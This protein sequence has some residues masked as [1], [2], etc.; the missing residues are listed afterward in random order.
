MMYIDTKLKQAGQIVVLVIQ[1]HEV[2]WCRVNCQIIGRQNL[3]SFVLF[4][5][6]L[7][8]EDKDLIKVSDKAELASMYLRFQS[9]EPFWLDE[10]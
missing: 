8:F 2:Y 10:G 5:S 9:I 7:F 6:K 4:Y 1:Y 3:F